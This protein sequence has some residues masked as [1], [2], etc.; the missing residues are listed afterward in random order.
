MKKGYCPWCGGEIED[1][2][3][4]ADGIYEV[5]GYECPSC[6][7]E[8]DLTVELDPMFEPEIPEAMEEACKPYDR[9]AVCDGW[10]AIHDCCRWTEFNYRFVN[11]GCPKGFG[12]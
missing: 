3:M 5:E 10:D 4:F 9:D 8:F 6:G 7:R 2:D 1:Y 12:E 11:D